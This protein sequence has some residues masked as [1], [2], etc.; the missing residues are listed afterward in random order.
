MY[1]LAL[2]ATILFAFS[3]DTESMNDTSNQNLD[4][5]RLKGKKHAVPISARLQNFADPNQSIGDLQACFDGDGNDLSG[6]GFA[7]T[8]NVISGHM[9][10]LGKLRPGISSED[11][12]PISGSFGNPTSCLVN[13][14]FDRATTVYHVNYVAANGD[15]L[16][17]VEDVLLIFNL[18]DYPDYSVG[19]FEGTIEI[20]GGTGRFK[21][22]SGNMVFVDA[23]FGPEG[24][25][26]E[27][28][29]EITY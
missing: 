27:L 8:R 11:G 18:V 25:S 5:V 20:V 4:A 13:V 21:N 14:D 3:C 17:T 24:S 9:T 6:I 22:A 1:K 19:S 7:L 26:W 15:E 29:G 2:A 16:H 28:E 23:I 10:H 12:V